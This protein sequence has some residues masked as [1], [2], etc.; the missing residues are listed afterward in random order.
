MH[1]INHNNIRL[2]ISNCWFFTLVEGRKETIRERENRETN[3][4]Y[5]GRQ[6]ACTL[7]HGVKENGL[8]VH[9]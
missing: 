8:R 2:K 3:K 4:N 9:T 6:K 1:G 7:R 5:E